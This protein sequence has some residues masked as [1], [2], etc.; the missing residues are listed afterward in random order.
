MRFDDGAVIVPRRSFSASSTLEPVASAA[1]ATP[2][3]VP[4]TPPYCRAHS[5]VP[6]ASICVTKT[7]CVLLGF[8]P[9]NVPVVV[10]VR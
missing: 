10:P 9:A 3:E 7:L 6:S 5:N 8:S 2:C 1:M 4:S